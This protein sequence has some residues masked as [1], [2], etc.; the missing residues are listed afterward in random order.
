MRGGLEQ[1]VQDPQDNEGHPAAAFGPLA[2]GSP[3]SQQTGLEM[4]HRKYYQLVA[5]SLLSVLGTPGPG[6]LGN[7]TLT[8]RHEFNFV[9]KDD[10][11]KIVNDKN[12]TKNL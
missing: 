6:V 1:E 12:K 5:K 4:T 9:L 3:A 11:T 7:P 8:I 10:E 2:R